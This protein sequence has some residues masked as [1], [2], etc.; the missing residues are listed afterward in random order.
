MNT[1]KQIELLKELAVKIKQ[2]QKIMRVGNIEFRESI[3]GRFEIIRW[4]P[5][6]TYYNKLDEFL[7]NDY[8]LSPDNTWVKNSYRSIDIS[9][10]SK[11]ELCFSIA[12]L[13]FDKDENTT[14]LTS[15]GERLLKLS[16]KERKD[17]WKI[18]KKASKFIK[19]KNRIE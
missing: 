12:S 9:F 1:S 6:T 10:F 19:K 2:K 3:T 4:Y 8:H 13:E 14:D 16:K 11:P 7:E 5:N 15:V 18:Y 17:F